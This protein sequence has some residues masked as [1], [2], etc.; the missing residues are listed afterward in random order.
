MLD[1]EEFLAKAPALFMED[2]NTLFVAA[3]AVAPRTFDGGGGGG[4]G[5]RLLLP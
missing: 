5:N 3:A 2:A 4:G 1:W